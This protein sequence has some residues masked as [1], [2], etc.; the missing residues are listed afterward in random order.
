MHNEKKITLM[1]MDGDLTPKEAKSV[2]DTA[3]KGCEM[4]YDVQKKALMEKWGHK[5]IPKAKVKPADAPPKAQAKKEAKKAEAK[6][7]AKKAAPKKT[8]KKREVKK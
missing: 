3:I 7:P 4:I 2:I 5:K 6:K 1:Q 8:T